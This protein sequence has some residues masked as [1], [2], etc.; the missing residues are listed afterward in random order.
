MPPFRRVEARSAGPGALG[1]LVPPGAQTLVI[2]RPRNLEWD[3]LPATWQG[4]CATPPRL[5]QFTREQAAEIARRMPE[6]LTQSVLTAANPVG[7]FGTVETGHFQVW[8]KVEEHY[9]IACRRLP[10]R[11]YEPVIFAT[12]EEA[13]SAALN[14]AA[15]FWPD[16]EA[17]QPYYF[18]TQLFSR[19]TPF[20]GLA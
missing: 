6:A 10:D 13:R 15:I 14:I 19:S 9:W 5:C 2:L 8:V 17:K 16:P 4:E 1:I 3:L 12:C 11:P 18:N 7:T 20:A